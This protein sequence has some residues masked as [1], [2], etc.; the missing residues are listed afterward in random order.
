MSKKSAA[1][2]T[3]RTID[4]LE[5]A[6]KKVPAMAYD[7]RSFEKLGA[8]YELIV[9]VNADDPNE[10]DLLTVRS[11]L[12]DAI[13]DIKNSPRDLRSRLTSTFARNGGRS[14]SILVREKLRE[15][16]F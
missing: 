12:M 16:W 6:T 5:E 10:A 8:L 3:L 2:I 15:Q 11:N 7:I 4:E 9:G 14:A 13:A 1:R